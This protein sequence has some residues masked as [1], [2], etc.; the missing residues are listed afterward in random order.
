M[1]YVA[2]IMQTDIIT[3]LI[4]FIAGLILAVC[5]LPQLIK[6]WKEKSAGDVSMSMLV[7]NLIAAL[8]YEIYAW[9][10]GLTPVVVMNGIFATLV[11]FEIMMKVYYDRGSSTNPGR[12]P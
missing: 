2:G 6:T 12:K 3:D 10:L 8:L 7:L 1:A 11:F 9:R 4:G 5:F